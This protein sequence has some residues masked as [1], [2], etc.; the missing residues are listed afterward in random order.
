MAV[1]GHL[2]VTIVKAVPLAT[3]CVKTW[4]K[5]V[6]SSHPI[7]FHRRQGGGGATDVFIFA[8]TDTFDASVNVLCE[9]VVFCKKHYIVLYN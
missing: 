2:P 8:Y 9:V 3:V 6:E 4:I 1:G 7:S 5:Q